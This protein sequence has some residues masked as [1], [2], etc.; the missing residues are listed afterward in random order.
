M[1][2]WKYDEQKSDWD[3]TVELVK[4]MGYKPKNVSF[5]SFIACILLHYEGNCEQEER[6]IPMEEYLTAGIMDGEEGRLEDFDY[7]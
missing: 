1:P 3:N 2:G 4:H 5:D 6:E 7:E